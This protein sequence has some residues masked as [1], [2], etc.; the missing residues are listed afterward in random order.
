MIDLN[1]IPASI[2]IGELKT[3]LKVQPNSRFGRLNEYENWD[4][5]RSLSDYLVKNGEQLMCV[6]QCIRTEGQPD[7]DDYDQ[8]LSTYKSQ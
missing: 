7:F 4:N 2:T 3:K 1:D 8:W 5:R 6:I